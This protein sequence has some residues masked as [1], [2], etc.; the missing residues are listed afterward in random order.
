MVCNRQEFLSCLPSP[1]LSQPL[2]C[3]LRLCPCLLPISATFT[4]PISSLSTK[5]RQCC[6][7]GKYIT[8]SGKKEKRVEGWATRL[9]PLE[10]GGSSTKTVG[11]CSK[12]CLFVPLSRVFS[13][14][15]CIYSQQ[16]RHRGIIFSLFPDRICQHRNVLAEEL[17]EKLSTNIRGLIRQPE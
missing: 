15:L 17:P 7:T 11:Y 9:F 5:H 2:L 14:Y 4:L 13:S 10:L 6:L 8:G 3:W 12:V 16:P 1:Q